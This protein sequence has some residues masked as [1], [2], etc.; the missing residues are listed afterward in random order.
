MCNAENQSLSWISDILAQLSSPR[1]CRISLSLVVDNVEDLHSPNSEFAVRDFS[2]AFF[3]DMRVLDCESI[4]KSL[5]GENLG[6]L[7][8]FVLEGRGNRDFLEK[9]IASTCP[10]LHSRAGL[11][12][13]QVHPSPLLPF[14]LLGIVFIGD[15]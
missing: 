2:P 12:E 9:H 14:R 11:S 3:N 8:E 4:G 10:E 5:T 6:A 7:R 15:I 1:L 13:S